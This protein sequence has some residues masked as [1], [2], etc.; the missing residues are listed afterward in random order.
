MKIKQIIF[1]MGNFCKAKSGIQFL[2]DHWYDLGHPILTI[3][4]CAL[5]T[6]T[7]GDDKIVASKKDILI[8]NASA[9]VLTLQ[10]VY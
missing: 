10:N 8:L 5:C 2:F 7:S 6:Q 4:H 1:F 3:C 9:P